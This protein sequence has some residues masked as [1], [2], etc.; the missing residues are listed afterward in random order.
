[1][2]KILIVDENQNLLNSL[3]KGLDK[4]HQFDVIT[5]SGAE[6]AIGLFHAHL[7]VMVL[8]PHSL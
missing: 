6:D 3:E 5:A 2:D 8:P 1:M 7:E 4:M